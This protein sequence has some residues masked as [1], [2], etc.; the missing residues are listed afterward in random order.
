MAGGRMC[1]LFFFSQ[2]QSDQPVLLTGRSSNGSK[3]E[4]NKDPFHRQSEFQKELTGEI[5]HPTVALFVTPC[6]GPRLRGMRSRQVSVSIVV[7]CRG[8]DWLAKMESDMVW[9]IHP[10][11]VNCEFL[12]SFGRSSARHARGYRGVQPRQGAI[13]L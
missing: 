8:E 6:F 10:F 13:R 12:F 7:P 3:K 11:F 1:L 5:S 2:Q 4:K 9:C